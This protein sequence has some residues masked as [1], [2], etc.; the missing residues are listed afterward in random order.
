MTVASLPTMAPV[1]LDVPPVSGRR[2]WRDRRLAMEDELARTG[3]CNGKR[4]VKLRMEAM[5]FALAWGLRLAGQYGRGVCNAYDLRLR[6]LDLHF[7]NLP[8][9]FDGFRLLHLSDLHIDGMPGLAEALGRVLGDTTA[10]ACVLTGDYRYRISG[11][12]EPCLDAMG[13]VLADLAAR[14]PLYGVLG[15][16]D[17]AAMVGVLEEM[18]LHLLINEQCRLVR[19][20]ESIVLAGTDDVRY[21]HTAH[22]AGALAGLD[23]AFAIALVHS[24]EYY[25]VAA[26]MGADLYLCGHT[27]G[28]QVCL[29]GGRPVV[30]HLDKG[31]AFA[32]GP[33]RHGRMQGVTTCGVGTSG[34][35]VR[36]HSRG[37][38][39]LLTLRRDS[40]AAASA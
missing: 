2:A 7:V 10:D 20:D 29:P 21:Y 19:G 6:Q 25:D 13:E 30:M 3:C 1:P 23:D 31:R 11:P 37:E 24:P 26:A 4:R 17:S 5:K 18:Q 14:A 39:L 40:G 28:G 9:A 15:N 22:T 32:R 8:P 16:H 33:W 38:A 35:P 36:F 34:P 12:A 27:H